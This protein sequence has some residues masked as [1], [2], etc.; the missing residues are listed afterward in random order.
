MIN[1][2]S[3]R[4]SPLCSAEGELRYMRFTIGDG[5]ESRPAASH[6]RM[7]AT[8]M[9]TLIERSRKSVRSACRASYY[10]PT[11]RLRIF[12][13]MQMS[14]EGTHLIS[15]VPIGRNIHQYHRNWRAFLLRTPFKPL[16][17]MFLS[18]SNHAFQTIN[19]NLGV[20]HDSS[21][22]LRCT[23]FAIRPDG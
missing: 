14:Q 13:R 11:S 19:H 17:I 2:P 3:W 16:F 20:M 23:L 15:H 22:T 5:G 7:S 6:Q 12:A 1:V 18:L 10:V 9:H 4:L 8:Q 21:T